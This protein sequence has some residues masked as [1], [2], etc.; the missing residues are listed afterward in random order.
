[1]P[2]SR[3]L[4]PV[5]TRFRT[6][7]AF[8]LI[9][10][11]VVIAIISVL[12]GMLAPALSDARKRGL[13]TRCASNLRQLGAG[14]SIYS[15]DNEGVIIPGRPGKY[16]DNSKNVYWVGNGYQFRPRWF[17][18]MG[19]AYGFFAFSQPSPNSADD[20]KLAVDGSP[21]FHC[22]QVPERINNRNYAY[23][24]NFQFLGNSRFKGGTEANGFI[25][26]PRKREH[27]RAATTVVSADA[28]GTAAGKP[29]SARTT[30]REDGSADLFA[31]GNHAWSLDPPR[32]TATSDFCDDSNRAPQHRSAPEMR[33]LGKASVLY[34]DSHVE[35]GDYESLGYVR[36]DDGSIAA[37]DPRSR[38]H[39]FSGR[40]RDDDPP[41][42]Q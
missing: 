35:P 36:Q 37:S 7:S 17:V 8:T 26:Y 41:P 13:A 19:A 6:R 2:A 33:H 22:P 1:M 15:D 39:L 9:E 10:L 16:A 30:Y 4:S 40:D 31:L 12:I 32:L 11:L 20:N 27:L 25:N 14:W 3:R 29:E 42:V 38:N 21:L 28:M 23:G 24:Y 34:A 5:H 18:Q